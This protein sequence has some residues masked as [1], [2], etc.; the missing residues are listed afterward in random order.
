MADLKAAAILWLDGSGLREQVLESAIH[1]NEIKDK[2]EKKK[3]DT[4]FSNPGTRIPVFTASRVVVADNNNMINAFDY[5]H[6]LDLEHNPVISTERNG[7][8]T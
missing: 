3:R 6:T 1:Q 7:Q 2:T 5:P 8:N 4:K